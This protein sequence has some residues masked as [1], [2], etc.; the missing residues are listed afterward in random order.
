MSP[1]L[2]NVCID[3]RGENGD[4]EERE[5]GNSLAFCMQMTWFCGGESE[6]TLNMMVVCMVFF[7]FF[8][9]RRVLKV[10]ADNSEVMVLGGE[11]RLV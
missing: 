9:F 10:N 11:E 7:F 8:F 1:W 5:S 3:E 4:G 2:F 6:E